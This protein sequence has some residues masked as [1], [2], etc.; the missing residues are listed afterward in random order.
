M[1]RRNGHDRLVPLRG[2]VHFR[3][4][5]EPPRPTTPARDS[6]AGVVSSS[7]KPQAYRQSSDFDQGVGCVGCALFFLVAVGIGMLAMYLLL[8]ANGWLPG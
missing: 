7:V 3:P 4:R 8:R 6:R 5:V 1:H 2:G